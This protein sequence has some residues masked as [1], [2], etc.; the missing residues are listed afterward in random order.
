MNGEKIR[1]WKIRTMVTD[2]CINPECY[3][4][5]EQLE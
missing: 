3:M 5:P 4:T 2:A 1:I